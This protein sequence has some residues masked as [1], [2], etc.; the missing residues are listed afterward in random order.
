[1]KIPFLNLAR[2]IEDTKEEIEKA[3]TSLLKKGVFILGPN[4]SRLEKKIAKYVGRRYAV[5]VGSGTDALH[6]AL[7]AK[8]IGVG[9][10]VITTPY[11]F[12]ATAEAIS[13]VGARPLFV[14][15]DLDSYN[16]DG[17]EL[18]GF[19]ERKCEEKKGKLFH[20]KTGLWIKAIM[21]VHLFGQCAEMERILDFAQRYKILVIEDAT[22]SFGAQRKIK[23]KWWRAG[24]MAEIGCFSFY[25]TKNL[26]AFGD[27]GMV[28]TS[29]KGVYQKL[30]L[31]RNHGMVKKNYH[32][33]IGWNS[34]LDEVQ[35]A[36]LLVNFRHLKE[37]NR[38][39]K[40]IFLYYNKHLRDKVVVPKILPFNRSVFNQYV[41]RTP[42]RD[43]LRFFL[44]KKG[45]ET[46]IYYPFPLHLQS[47]YRDLGYKKGDFPKAEKASEEILALPIDPTLKEEEKEYV[48]DCITSFFAKH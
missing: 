31:L 11:T 22:Q 32:F 1:M 5:G 23:G 26:W 40:E 12:F 41:I 34:R 44:K 9:D 15:I 19:V 21:P 16:L 48:V 30:R 42:R 39:R 14:D 17:K 45:I 24:G 47:C 18:L 8:G 13:Q 28:V 25:P 2:Q 37:R 20:K 4:L 38:R 10:G 27:G 6:L 43:S 33:C 3:V 35:A 46:E 7:R 36:F 29:E